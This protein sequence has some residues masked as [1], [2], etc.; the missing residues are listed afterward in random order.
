MARLRVL[1]VLEATEGGTRTHLRDLVLGLDLA[2][3]ELAVAVNAGRDPGFAAD[4]A[5]FAAA[6][7]AVHRGPLVREPSLSDLGALW[8]LRRLM[9]SGRF[10]LVHT[11]SSKAGFLGRLAARLEGVPAIYTP[12]AYA[13]LAPT[14]PP[15]KRRLYIGLER[16]AAGWGSHTIAVSEGER[17]AA[18]AHRLT[19]PDRITVVPNGVDPAALQAAADAAEGRRALG[20]GDRLVLLAV[21]RRVAQKGDRYLLEAFAALPGD[22]LLA[23]AGDGPL[24]DELAVQAARLGVADRVRFLGRRDDIPNLLAAADVFVLPSLYEGASYA[25]LEAM[26]LGRACVATAVQGSA[27]V[28]EDQQSGLLV[29]PGEVPSLTAALR[30]LIEDRDL[31]LRLGAAAAARVA[32][33]YRVEAMVAGTA[34]VYGRVARPPRTSSA[35]G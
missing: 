11:H 10:D 33:K 30:L 29:P 5:R 7:V 13:F 24:T 1:Q 22:T 19:T 23:L 8:W 26:A 31:R 20:A 27:E 3:F 12:N 21:G 25:L 18:L 4:L 6:G 34:E 9:R 16:L 15:A 17:Q 28:I 32:Q 35:G 14:L 2:R